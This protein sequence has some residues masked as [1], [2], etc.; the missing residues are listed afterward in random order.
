MRASSSSAPSAAVVPYLGLGAAAAP[1]RRDRSAPAS[2]SPPREVTPWF[3]GEYE[4]LVRETAA[5][6]MRK[7]SVKELSE[8]D[9]V[10]LYHSPGAAE[11]LCAI[12][13]QT[14]HILQLTC[15]CFL[16]RGVIVKLLLCRAQ[17]K[18]PS[19]SNQS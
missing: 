19:C 11:V 8:L 18:N 13:N 9:H 6:Q 10:G 3:A 14:R 12:L 2:S 4:P 1:A 7:A 17:M 15:Y 5:D 16:S